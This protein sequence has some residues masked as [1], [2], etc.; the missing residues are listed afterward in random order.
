LVVPNIT[1]Q[2]ELDE[3]IPVYDTLFREKIGRETGNHFDL[4]GTDEDD[5]EATTPQILWPSNYGINLK[6]TLYFANAYHVAQQ[7]LGEKAYFNGDHAI[8]KPPH[9]NTPTPWHQDEAYWNPAKIYNSVGFWLALQDVDEDNGCMHF[10]PG[11]QTLEVAN[12]HCYNNNNRIHGLEIDEVNDELLKKKVI[13]PLKAGGCTIHYCRTLH[14]TSGN[15]T[16]QGRRAYTLTFENEP[17]Q[18]FGGRDF[19]WNTNKN[20]AR[21]ERRMRS[22]VT[23]ND[24]GT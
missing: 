12:H 17:Q 14:Y 11:T 20:L 3:L 18:D 15:N 23:G 8:L 13:V 10:I 21:E 4:V 1:T 19:Y 16:D 5:K 7:L 6:E 24:P 22:G 9:T 2:Q